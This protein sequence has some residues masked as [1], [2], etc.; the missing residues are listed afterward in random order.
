[1]SIRN[2]TWKGF[3]KLSLKVFEKDDKVTTAAFKRFQV[4]VI[5]RDLSLIGAL[6]LLTNRPYIEAL[7]E[8]ARE[9]LDKK[10][11]NIDEKA[12]EI[13]DAL[14]AK[15]T[16]VA[17]DAVILKDWNEPKKNFWLDI[18]TGVGISAVFYILGIITPPLSWPTQ[19][20]SAPKG[21]DKTTAKEALTPD[22][23]EP[24]PLQQ[25]EK[26]PQ[27]STQG[28]GASPRILL[29]VV[30]PYEIAPSHKID[31]YGRDPETGESMI[32]LLEAG[33]AV[34][35][36]LPSGDELTIKLSRPQ[37]TL[38]KLKLMPHFR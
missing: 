18:K 22:S 13:L 7:L 5:N 35:V 31:L 28:A 15:V 4:D 37:T 14:D 27:N 11:Q 21:K 24:P 30:H 1:M 29:S 34:T 2:K 36:P 32:A 6:G 25:T 10:R 8:Q 16:N 9:D 3:I 20:S 17:E 33:R 12:L 23:T 26:Q 38:P 19:D